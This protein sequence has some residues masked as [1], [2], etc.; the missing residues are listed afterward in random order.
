[1]A[2]L[3]TGFAGRRHGQRSASTERRPAAVAAETEGGDAAWRR[4][5]CASGV[6]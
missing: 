3:V 6:G 4:A 5:R 1:M 2:A